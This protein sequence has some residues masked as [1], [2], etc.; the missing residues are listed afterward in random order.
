[1][2]ITVMREVARADMNDN[3]GV[4]IWQDE[5]QVDLTTDQAREYAA[6][7]ARAADEA[8]R[9]E[10]QDRDAAYASEGESGEFISPTGEAV[11]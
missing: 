9:I 10:Q 8:D 6:E 4:T 7:I 2:S 1:M 5:E 11:L 3:Y